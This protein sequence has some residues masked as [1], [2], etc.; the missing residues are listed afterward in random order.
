MT[1]DDT[2]I[3]LL[4]LELPRAERV[5]S[6]R[7]AVA[8]V[9]ADLRSLDRAD[10]LVLVSELVAAVAKDGSSPVSLDV[11]R[12]DI[13]LRVE[14]TGDAV[15][16]PLDPLAVA[17]LDQVASEWFLDEGVAGFEVRQ[18]S[19]FTS[20]DD[21]S[22][23]FKRCAIGDPDARG[24]LARRYQGFARSL[25]RRFHKSGRRRED[26]E[27]VAALGLVN[28]LDRFD[29]ERGVKFTTFAARTIDGELKRHLRD[30]GWSIRV[31]RGLQELGLEAARVA[32]ESSQASGRSPTLEDLAESM[33]EDLGE[34]AKALL[35]RKSFEAAS[36][37]A[38]LAG[39]EGLHMLDALPSHDDRL[40]MA[41]EWSDLSM[42]MDRL[43]ERERRI[44]FLRF[45][46]DLSQSEIAEIVGI[47]QM[48]VSRLLARSIDDLR[49]WIGEKP[50]GSQEDVE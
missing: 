47:S 23:L 44:L 28:A 26:L 7:R 18:M 5:R 32:S 35:A 21:E 39:H 50:S 34:V 46:K 22:A 40:L 43:P 48:H 13:G 45:F 6:A 24:E 14:A 9:I 33:D 42:V 36:L 41:P 20:A 30:A 38:P 4:H 25:A 8:P 11:W 10:V 31:P 49:T 19:T 16:A 3:P 37:D 2:R 15:A 12:T 29:P 27:Q 17:V 1:V